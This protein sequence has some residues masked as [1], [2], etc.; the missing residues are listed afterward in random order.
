[1]IS[2]LKI[3]SNAQK[4]HSFTRK[5]WNILNFVKFLDKKTEIE[6]FFEVW[7]FCFHFSNDFTIQEK[8]LKWNKKFKKWFWLQ[9]A[10]FLFCRNYTEW[11]VCWLSDSRL[12][13]SRLRHL[14]SEAKI[15]GPKKINFGLKRFNYL[16]MKCLSLSYFQGLINEDLHCCTWFRKT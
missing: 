15:L 14:G 13:S 3:Q 12:L 1:M 4:L 11:C 8:L 9:D 7:K 16:K 10:I 5:N 2:K 6:T